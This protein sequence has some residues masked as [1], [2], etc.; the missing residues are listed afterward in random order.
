MPCNLICPSQSP[1]VTTPIQLAL[2]HHKAL[3][4]SCHMLCTVTAAQRPSLPHRIHPCHAPTA[5][6]ADPHAT[7]ADLPSAPPAANLPGPATEDVFD[8]SSTPPRPAPVSHF[9]Q[10]HQAALAFLRPERFPTPTDTA[11]RLVSRLP[12]PPTFRRNYHAPPSRPAAA[13]AAAPGPRVCSTQEFNM[14][15]PPQPLPKAYTA[16]PTHQHTRPSGAAALAVHLPE[17]AAGGDCSSTAA[18]PP[19]QDEHMDWEPQNPVLPSLSTPVATAAPQTSSECDTPA[20][21]QAGQLATPYWAPVATPPLL[22]EFCS[23]ITAAAG[24]PP[25]EQQQRSGD[26]SISRYL[27]FAEPEGLPTLAEAPQSVRLGLAAMARRQRERLLQCKPH[28]RTLSQSEPPPQHEVE[29]ATSH[30]YHEVRP[31]STP[32]PGLHRPASSRS[33]NHIQADI[34]CCQGYYEAAD[35]PL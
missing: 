1:P 32:T 29:S 10:D 13:D 28:L 18:D 23:I 2:P 11:S 26:G 25:P 35:A 27:E 6:L 3:T 12:P 19:P 7:H 9:E 5:T 14:H 34:L 30:R 8:D 31:A 15:V 4:A 20:A 21:A 24:P 16:A 22:S 17:R 33:R